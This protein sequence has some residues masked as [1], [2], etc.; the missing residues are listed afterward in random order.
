MD[1]RSCEVKRKN[2]TNKQPLI[3]ISSKN[4]KPV[5]EEK[6]VVD[7]KREIVRRKGDS[8]FHGCGAD[9]A[10]NTCIDVLHTPSRPSKIHGRWECMI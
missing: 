5:F 3:P 8:G 10:L 1:E 2:E 7:V 4:T 6:K 9:V